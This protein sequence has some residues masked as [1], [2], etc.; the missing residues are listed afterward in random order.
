MMVE[1]L[2]LSRT[3][4]AQRRRGLLALITLC[5]CVSVVSWE[6]LSPASAHQLLDRVVARVNG[7][8]IT[9]TDMNAALGLGLVD[10]AGGEDPHSAATRQ[11]IER[12]LILAEVARFAPPEPDQA[13]IEREVAAL[14]ARAGARL[15]MLM[16]STGLDEQRLRDLARESLRIQAYL[17]QRFGANLQVSDEE[18]EQYYRGHPE[19]FTRSGT[20]I[21]YEEAAP[22]ARQRASALRRS[23]LIAQWLR[24]LRARAEVTTPQARP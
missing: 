4:E 13:A 19:E 8:A 24:D 2:S 17:S 6:R 23:A 14:K 12:Q 21:S 1:R 3:T 20:L 16:Q 15:D 9:L 11:L 5:L 7:I 22:V 10:V 18:V